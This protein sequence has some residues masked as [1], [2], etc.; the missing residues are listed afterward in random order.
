MIIS[1]AFG[2]NYFFPIAFLEVVPDYDCFNANISGNY[3]AGW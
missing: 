1:I 2:F 3:D